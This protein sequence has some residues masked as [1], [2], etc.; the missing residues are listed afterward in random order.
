M[1]VAKPW[2]VESPAP[3]TSHSLGGFPV[4]R[5]SSTIAFV[6]AIAEGLNASR[7]RSRRNGHNQPGRRAA[8]MRSGPQAPEDADGGKRD[9]EDHSRFPV[10]VIRVM[11][12]PVRKN[13]RQA[14]CTAPS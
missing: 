9:G 11:L 3:V 13:L 5:F 4:L 1:S 12:V 6:C 10:R 8:V 14:E 7:H 2:I